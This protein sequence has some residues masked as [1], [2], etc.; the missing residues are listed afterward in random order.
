MVMIRDKLTEKQTTKPINISLSSPA[1]AGHNSDRLPVPDTLRCMAKGAA[2]QNNRV[3]VFYEEST[4]MNLRLTLS[5]VHVP[6][7]HIH[8][9]FVVVFS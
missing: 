6:F 2:N 8:D 3:N 5:G 7:D 9:S 4:H 1:R